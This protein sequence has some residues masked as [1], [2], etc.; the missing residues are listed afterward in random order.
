MGP[1][2][3]PEHSIDR[4]PD[5]NGNYEPSNCRWATPAQQAANKPPPLTFRDNRR[6]KP[7]EP[8]W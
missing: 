7:L 8:D 6:N 2:P 5:F 3:S 1:K 4:Y